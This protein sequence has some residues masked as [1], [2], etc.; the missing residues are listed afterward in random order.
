M[1]RLARIMWAFCLRHRI[2]LLPRWIPGTLMVE[3]GTDGRSRPAPPKLLS[4]A[5]H[6][7][8]R[9][10]PGWFA[11][12]Y[13]QLCARCNIPGLTVDRFARRVC[14]QLPRFS[15]DAPRELGALQPRNAFAHAW[16]RDAGGAT[17]FN[18][19]YPPHSLIAD[20]AAYTRT[21]KAW[22]AMLVPHWVHAWYPA[23]VKSA[24]AAFP[25]PVGRTPHF[26]RLYEGAW[27]SVTAHLFEPWV[28]VLDHRGDRG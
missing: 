2:S 5:D 12:V 11:W 4:S 26:E 15:S 1:T 27:Q 20:A 18:W 8:W 16:G 13:T 7:H 9:L 24:A 19:A 21:C 23:L 22:T 3:C 14:A 6:D 10:H 25:L 28:I 17:E